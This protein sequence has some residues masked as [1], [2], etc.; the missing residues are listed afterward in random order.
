MI[1]RTITLFRTRFLLTVLA[2]VVWA[3]PV[4]AA[5]D[6]E[7]MDELTPGEQY[8]QLSL[9]MLV[10]SGTD[11]AL[12]ELLRPIEERQ[13]GS[14]APELAL[15][16]YVTPLIRIVD[17]DT[18]LAS[19][20]GLFRYARENSQAI[21]ERLTA[22]AREHPILISMLDVNEMAADAI[23]IRNAIADSIEYSDVIDD[24]AAGERLQAFRGQTIY[25]R[26]MMEYNIFQEELASITNEAI[27]DLGGRL[28]A[29]QR[30]FEDDVDPDLIK[31]RVESAEIMNQQTGSRYEDQAMA[32]NAELLMMLILM[33]SQV[34]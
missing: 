9:L 13:A 7:A 28:D 11:P 14:G 3:T 26:N 17:Q 10:T 30:M 22:I 20:A 6:L 5:V 31:R 25:L 12:L 23:I 15:D 16:D 8:R 32:R 1:P 2:L 33:E 4:G 29:Y 27:L 34:R 18:L 21:Q 24:P 19:A